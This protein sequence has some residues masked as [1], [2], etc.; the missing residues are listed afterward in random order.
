MMQEAIERIAQGD[1]SCIL[2]RE[3]EGMREMHGSGIRPL[4]A[5]YMEG[6]LEG[7][8]VAD[9]IIGKAAAM[10]LFQGGAKEV[11]GH[12]MSTQGKAYLEERGIALSYGT[13]VTSIINRRG[14]GICPMEETV[15]EIDDAREG[16]AALQE[17]MRRLRADAEKTPQ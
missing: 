15:A 6:A 17:T 9:K 16:I 11:Y 12:V 10:I 3:G 8:A 4:M 1:A 2:V 13:C 14:D 5:C 7:A